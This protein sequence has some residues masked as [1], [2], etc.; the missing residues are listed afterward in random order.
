MSALLFHDVREQRHEARPLDGGGKFALLL[1]RN[2]R[3]ARGHDLAALGNVALQQLDVLVVDLRSIGAGERAGLAAAEKRPAGQRRLCAHP[4]APSVSVVASP[5][6][7]RRSRFSSR[8][9]LRL[10]LDCSKAST[11]TVMKRNTSSLIL[12][13]RSSSKIALAGAFK[14]RRT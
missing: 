3:D 13:W 6:R 7:G 4:M 9:R 12:S 10:E 8:S 2:S 14:L 11:R 5:S 1:G